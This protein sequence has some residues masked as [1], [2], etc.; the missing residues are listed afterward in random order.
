M[1]T[2]TFKNKESGEMFDLVLKIS[3]LDEFKADHEH[4]EQ[5][6]VPPPLVAGVNQKPDNGF[7]DV[8]KSIKKAS[9]RGNTI[10]TF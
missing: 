1:P 4:L 8:L 3:Q 6:I 9:G 5:V 2:Y 7:R 10:E